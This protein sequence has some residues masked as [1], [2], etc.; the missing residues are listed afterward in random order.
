MSPSRTLSE[1]KDDPILSATAHH[2]Q[3]QQVV[4]EID[5]AYRQGLSPHNNIDTGI[6]QRQEDNANNNIDID[7]DNN[8]ANDRGNDENNIWG[9]HKDTNNSSRSDS[10]SSLSC[11]RDDST[12]R[13]RSGNHH[14]TDVL[15]DALMMLDQ[16]EQEQLPSNEFLLKVAFFSFMS[17]ALTQL[18]FAFIANSQAMKGDSAAMIVDAFTYLFN[19]T[20]ERRKHQLD[21]ND[22][23]TENY[24]DGEQAIDMR[25]T[26]AS[27]VGP[28]PANADYGELPASSIHMSTSTLANHGNGYDETDNVNG[29]LV[30]NR[31]II[32]TRTRRK[33]VLQL[34]IVPPILSVCTLAVV[35]VWVTTKAVAVLRLDMHRSIDQ[36]DRPNINIMLAFS[37]FNLGLD[38]LNVFCFARAKHLMGYSVVVQQQ[39]QD[40]ESNAHPHNNQRHNIL[41][42]DCHHD[43]HHHSNKNG[44]KHS[45]LIDKNSNNKNGHRVGSANQRHRGRLDRCEEGGLCDAV[46][47]DASSI[48]PLHSTNDDC[49]NDDNNDNVINDDLQQTNADGK[50][51]NRTV[52]QRDDLHHKH[53]ALQSNSVGHGKIIDPANPHRQHRDEHDDDGDEGANLNMCSAYTHVFADTLRSI[54]VIIAAITA[55]LVSTVTPEEADATAAI[56]VSVL[57]ALSLIPLVQG[58]V[59][60]VGELRSIHA[61]ERIEEH[62]RFVLLRSRSSS[63]TFEMT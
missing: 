53:L 24:G 60:S 29:N 14:E 23:D 27:A 35:T 58:L 63:S 17:F 19:W 21:E 16:Q 38:A 48:I 42:D 37:V 45:L 9:Y 31:E 11:R 8:T 25:N 36:Q 32:Q 49:D 22:T 52:H 4:T 59:R 50:Q 2:H 6:N 20:A 39:Q 47:T 1:H 3:Q 46:S 51:E 28:N 26:K 55:E 33:L 57:I 43:H 12:D 34:E 40:G 62:R 5:R 7:I 41:V 61:Q 10:R 15:E 56:I 44:A 30:Q 13:R 54:A 18:V